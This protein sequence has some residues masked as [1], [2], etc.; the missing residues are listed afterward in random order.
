MNKELFDDAIGEVPPST[1][2]LDAAISRGRRAARLSR[3]ANP[4]A[5]AGVAVVLTA[6]AVAFTMAQDDEAGTTGVASPPT[7]TTS[8]EAPPTGSSTKAPTTSTSST[9]GTAPNVPEPKAPDACSRTDLESAAEV[10]AR[11]TATANAAV[12]GQRQDL[13]LSPNKSMRES[14]TTP[15]EFFQSTR[16]T[17]YGADA[18]ICEKFSDFQGFATTDSPQGKGSIAMAV[19]ATYY[20]QAPQC[21]VPAND[22]ARYCETGTGPN[23]VSFMKQTETLENGLSVY[24]VSVLRPE[25]VIV[26][27]TAE[28]VGTSVKAGE[29]STAA[30]PP[31]THDQMIAVAADPGMTL[32]P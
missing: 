2:N 28:N 24:Q 15:L 4:V 19:G 8:S 26:N 5:A 27:I 29:A 17:P 16:D 32:F 14:A 22:P 6:G 20:P 21:E 25:G 3:V 13:Q 12:K 30:L 23:G 11:L 10:N 1:I 9:P 18:P 7:S 31:L